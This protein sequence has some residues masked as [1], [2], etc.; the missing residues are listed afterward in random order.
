M[1]SSTYTDEIYTAFR[2][3]ILEDT[4][5][6]ESFDVAEIQSGG[7]VSLDKSFII[8]IDRRRVHEASIANCNDNYYIWNLTV[9]IVILRGNITSSGGYTTDK[10]TIFSYDDQVEAAFYRALDILTG[11]ETINIVSAD[12]VKSSTPKRLVADS[13]GFLTMNIDFQIE[14]YGQKLS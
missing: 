5:L 6:K 12:Y 1:I 13:N 11:Y 7:V 2:D 3:A 9:T 4:D 8:N 14:G 10:N